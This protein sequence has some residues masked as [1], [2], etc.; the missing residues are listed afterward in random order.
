MGLIRGSRRT[1]SQPV[2]IS[3]FQ[4]FEHKGRL[5]DGVWFHT[6]RKHP[7]ARRCH[8]GA[9]YEQCSFYCALQK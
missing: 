8:W 1:S 4:S 2:Q 9:A 5:S 6:S 7:L 3:Q